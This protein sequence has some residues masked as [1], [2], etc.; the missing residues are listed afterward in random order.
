M[1]QVQNTDAGGS[2]ILQQLRQSNDRG[3][4]CLRKMRQGITGRSKILHTMRRSSKIERYVK[5]AT[6]RRVNI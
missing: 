5:E 6:G 1:F 2:T 3:T 4:G